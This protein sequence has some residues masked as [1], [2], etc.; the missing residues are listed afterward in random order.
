[1]M[2]NNKKTTKPL[3]SVVEIHLEDWSTDYP[4][5]VILYGTKNTDIIDSEYTE[6]AEEIIS[7]L[8]GYKEDI[9]NTKP[10]I[11]IVYNID[12]F[13]NA[14]VTACTKKVKTYLDSVRFKTDDVSKNACVSSDCENTETAKIKC[15]I[16]PSIT[17]GKCAWCCQYCDDLLCESRCDIVINVEHG[18]LNNIEEKCLYV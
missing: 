7:F 14:K 15:G 17:E 2:K 16:D 11:R 5:G 9:A 4:T 6:S 8:E 13:D 12:D 18:V 1:M 10:E 3:L